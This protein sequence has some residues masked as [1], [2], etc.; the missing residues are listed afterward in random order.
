M[1]QKNSL[2]LLLVIVGGV[3]S[4]GS[5]M[6][7]I[8][9]D[10]VNASAGAFNGIW[11]AT[12]V[13]WFFTATG[14]YQLTDLETVFRSVPSAPP[15]VTAFVMSNTPGN[16]GTLLGSGN[17]FPVAGVFSGAAFAPITVTAGETLFLGFENVAGLGANITLDAGATS[18]GTFYYD[19]GNSKLFNTSGPG[20]SSQPILELTGEA[21]PEPS[22]WILLLTVLALF[23]AAAG[24]RRA[25][26]GHGHP[27]R[28]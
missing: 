25:G 10:S 8:I 26:G 21:V 27:K 6:A 22:A 19:V 14:S 16:G 11:G 3:L 4:S 17:F 5:A 7:D 15:N 12:D 9:V 18:L 23:G 13:G 28:A 24:I 20:V 1:F 2:R